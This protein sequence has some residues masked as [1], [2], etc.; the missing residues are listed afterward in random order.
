MAKSFRK[1]RLNESIK[2]MLSELVLTGVKAS[3]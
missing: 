2:E 1:E 3:T